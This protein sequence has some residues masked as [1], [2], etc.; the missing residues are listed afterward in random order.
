MNDGMTGPKGAGGFVE[1]LEPR[2]AGWGLALRGREAPF[3][4]LEQLSI[5]LDTFWEED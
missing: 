5:T 2:G 1:A 3:Q 4:A